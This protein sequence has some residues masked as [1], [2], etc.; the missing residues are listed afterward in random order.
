LMVIAP[1][2]ITDVIA[3]LIP[4][5]YH[6]VSTKLQAHKYDVFLSHNWGPDE[7]GR[8]NHERVVKLK[9]GLERAGLSAW[10]DEEI[11]HDDLT[12][13]MSHGIEHSKLVAVFITSSYID[14]VQGNGPRGLDD[15]CKNEFDYAIRRLGAAKVI[16]V[17]MD[18][19]CKDSNAWTGAIGF[20]LGGQIYFDMSADGAVEDVRKLAQL[21]S[22]LKRRLP[23]QRALLRS[24]S[25]GRLGF[26]GLGRESGDRDSK[27]DL[28]H[29]AGATPDQSIMLGKRLSERTGRR[30]SLRKMGAP[31]RV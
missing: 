10:L 3:N 2:L 15:A 18:P 28:D 19:R 22:F 13:Q 5:F 6:A 31:W 27:G 17:V 9:E 20:K 4:T 25:S 29:G 8:D 7:L 30:P 23:Q 1:M 12:N 26:G 14:K 21:S 11:L 16:P 24:K